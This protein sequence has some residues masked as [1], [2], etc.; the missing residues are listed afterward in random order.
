[1]SHNVTCRPVAGRHDMVREDSFQQALSLALS[2]WHPAL[3]GALLVALTNC[4]GRTEHDALSSADTSSS[5]AGQGG[6]KSTSTGTGSAGTSGAGPQ[7]ASGDAGGGTQ[8]DPD[9]VMDPPGLDP[10]N[11]SLSTGSSC[12]DDSLCVEQGNTCIVPSSEDG[13]VS[14]RG[15]CSRD[16]S[17]IACADG[18]ECVALGTMQLCVPHCPTGVAHCG[19]ASL[20]KPSPGGADV[21]M[22]ACTDDEDCA[23]GLCDVTTGLCSQTLQPGSNPTGA[24]C[25]PGRTDECSGACETL[26]EGSVFCTRPCQQGTFNTCELCLNT[27]G[28]FQ[29][30]ATG[31]CFQPCNCNRDC[32]HPDFICDPFTEHQDQ[33]YT[34][35]RFT[36]GVC[37]PA[38]QRPGV[39]GIDECLP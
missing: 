20:C 36:R 5:T 11:G 28:E 33:A 8:D 21:C 16:C 13:G 32:F 7:P 17:E 6:F 30:S 12:A 1:M 4:S 9:A 22:P 24:P 23:V 26:G 2:A 25:T 18:E 31:A 3:M 37:L 34:I 35:F 38:E 39:S 27:S 19:G 15:I 14:A 10:G 29:T